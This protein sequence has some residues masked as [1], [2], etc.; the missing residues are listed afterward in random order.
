VR[1]ISA[2][3]PVAV[4][5]AQVIAVVRDDEDRISYFEGAADPRS[6]DGATATR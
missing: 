2:F 6:P 1:P 5:C 4:G 3:D